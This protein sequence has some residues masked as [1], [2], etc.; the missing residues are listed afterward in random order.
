MFRSMTVIRELTL[1]PSESHIYKQSVRIRRYG[2]CNG[3][4]ACYIKSMVVCVCAVYC[5]E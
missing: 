2:L 4:V 3:V 1:E 5:A